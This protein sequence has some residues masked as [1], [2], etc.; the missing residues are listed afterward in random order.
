VT[1]NV[2]DFVGAEKFGVR[3]ITPKQF[4]NELRG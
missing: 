4:L 2:R 3:I 1:H